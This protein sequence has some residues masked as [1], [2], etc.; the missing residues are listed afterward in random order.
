M[1]LITRKLSKVACAHP[2]RTLTIRTAF[3][4]K[5]CGPSRTSTLTGRYPW[6]AGSYDMQIDNDAT[7]V[8]FTLY[9]SLLRD[10]VSARAPGAAPRHRT[11]PTN[12]APQG[13]KTAA[14]GKWDVCVSR[15]ERATK[16]A[17]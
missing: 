8:N 6:G 14:L 7:T 1:I 13:Y 17:L 5:I 9:P 10:A 3:S 15:P 4:F 11:L 16:K 2:Y 12:N